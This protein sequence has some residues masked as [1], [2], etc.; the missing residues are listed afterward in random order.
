MITGW[1]H[2]STGFETDDADNDHLDPDD[3]AIIRRFLSESSNDG[4]DPDQEAT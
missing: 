4:D 2:Q 3:E 1:L